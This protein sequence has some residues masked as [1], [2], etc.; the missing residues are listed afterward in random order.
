MRITVAHS[1]DSDDA[2][3]F[4]GLASGA[5]DTGGSGGRAPPVGHRDAEPGGLRGQVRGHRRLVPRLRVPPR[6]LHPA[7]ARR[8]HGRELRP[9]RRGARGRPAIARRRARGGARAADVGLPGA[10][11]LRPGGRHR[12][13]AVRR[14]PG[15][16]AP[17]RRGGGPA[18]PR[19]PADLPGRGAA[20]DRGPRRVVGR[21]D[22]RAA[23]A[24]RRQRASAATSG[25]R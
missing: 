18:D 23:A 3:M 7:A 2:F 16:R 10:Q 21:A 12:G 19:G 22:R 9:D 5:V 8:Q 1:P 14:D 11:A 20:Q 15:R 13:D 6:P 25:P 4:Y 17:R 24:A